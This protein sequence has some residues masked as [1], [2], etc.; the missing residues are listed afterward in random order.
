M[1]TFINCTPHAVCLNDGTV[2]APSGNRAM[3]GTNYGPVNKNGIAEQ[4]HGDVT[5]LPE[6]QPDTFYIVAAPVLAAVKH[7]RSDVVA[8]ATAH[9][10][11][12]RENGQ[13]KSVPFFVR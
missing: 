1:A 9:P 8:P 13:P 11:C 3:V 10:D 12:V 6:P 2:F 4:T 7:L 5:G